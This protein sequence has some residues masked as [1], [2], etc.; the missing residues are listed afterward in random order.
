[1]IC[2]EYEYKQCLEPWDLVQGELVE[3]VVSGGVM[4]TFFKAR[5]FS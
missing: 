1:M 5:V 3:C 2:L 4:Y